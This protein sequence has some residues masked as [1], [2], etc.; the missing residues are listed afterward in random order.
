MFAKL[1]TSSYLSISA[2]MNLPNLL[3][4]IASGSTQ[5]RVRTLGIGLSNNSPGCQIEY[6]DYFCNASAMLSAVPSRSVVER[7]LQ[8]TVRQRVQSQLY[9]LS[10]CHF[11]C[12]FWRS[13][14]FWIINRNI[15][16]NKKPQ[17]RPMVFV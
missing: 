9:S 15:G 14:R 10:E 2:A 1:T 6:L 13:W 5:G 16:G 12:Y 7:N 8:A 11:T 17:S 3:G 4:V